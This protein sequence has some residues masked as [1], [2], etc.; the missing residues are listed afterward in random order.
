MV[1]K[2]ATGW[3]ATRGPSEEELGVC[4]FWAAVDMICPFLDWQSRIGVRFAQARRSGALG[5]GYCTLGWDSSL[6][7]AGNGRISFG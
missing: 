7:A 5:F 4:W 3:R 2:A 6:A 1:R